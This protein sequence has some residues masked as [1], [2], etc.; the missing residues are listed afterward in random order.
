MTAKERSAVPK[1]RPAG[2]LSSLAALD[3]RLN[4]SCK[5]YI[6]RSGG[7]IRLHHGRRMGRKSV[8][9]AVLNQD[10]FSAF[11]KAFFAISI[12]YL[13]WD[14]GTG[15]EESPSDQGDCWPRR[16]SWALAQ[17]PPSHLLS[18]NVT[19]AITSVA[20]AV[21][22][23]TTIVFALTHVAICAATMGNAGFRLFLNNL[24]RWCPPFQKS[25]PPL[26]FNFS[27]ESMYVI[28]KSGRTMARG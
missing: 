12:S 14:W 4:Q 13:S 6:P 28:P 26:A 16:G 5:T 11:A 9:G 1:R 15:R 19:G 27:R 3:N 20:G 17:D 7:R 2:S 24:H 10:G 18:G 21:R 22:L 23:T 8:G 25:R